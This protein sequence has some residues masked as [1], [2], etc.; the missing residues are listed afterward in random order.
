MPGSPA[1]DPNSP[2]GW[3][4][5]QPNDC[6]CSSKDSMLLLVRRIETGHQGTICPGRKERQADLRSDACIRD[7]KDL[8]PL[9]GSPLTPDRCRTNTPRSDNP[10]YLGDGRLRLGA[11]NIY[12][13]ASLRGTGLVPG[14]E[15]RRHPDGQRGRS[16]GVSRRLRW[17]GSARHAPFL[18][19]AIS[20]VLV[21]RPASFERLGRTGE[22][23]AR[24]GRRTS[25][26]PSPLCHRR[27]GCCPRYPTA[28]CGLPSPAPR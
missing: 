8:S 12:R 6:R 25:Q 11:R 9:A 3:I 20:R 5:A 1:Q 21:P 19:L 28:R 13:D 18:S 22:A 26:Q 4:T 27:S 15:L 10:R 14:P 2:N 17:D 16:P 23:P 24:P 7:R